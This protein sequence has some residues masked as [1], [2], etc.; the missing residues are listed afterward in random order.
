MSEASD[1]PLAFAHIGDLHLTRAAEPNFADLLLIVAQLEVEFGA[2]LD[3]VVLPGDNADNGLPAQYRLAATAL[4]MLTVPVHAIAGDHDMEQGTLDAFHQ[5]LAPDSLPKS[6]RVR[7]RRCLFLDINGRGAG[8][9]DFRLGAA[10]F[11]WI[12]RELQA[13]WRTGETCLAFM[14]AYPVDLADGA[15]RARL[16]ALFDQYDVSELVPRGFVVECATRDGDGF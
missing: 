8:G 2:A 16:T 3:F 14:H 7:E 10:Q 11:G 5:H 15:E 12:E 13:S 4:K 1:S 9:P 6:I